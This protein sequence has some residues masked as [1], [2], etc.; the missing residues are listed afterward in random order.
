M[1]GDK[2]HFTEYEDKII[3]IDEIDGTDIKINPSFYLHLALL[4]CQKSLQ[5]DDVKAGFLQFI[6]IV[7]HTEILARSAGIIDQT[8]YDEEIKTF[9]TKEHYTKA[10]V[11]IPQ[12]TRLANKK[13]ELITKQFFKNTTLVAP[14]KA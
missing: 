8:N 9:K 4:N 3:D 13:I 12:D 10:V 2:K 6:T 5:K 14:L 11:G 7:E 1:E